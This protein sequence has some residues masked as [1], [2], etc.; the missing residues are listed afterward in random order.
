MEKKKVLQISILFLT[1]GFLLAVVQI[2]HFGGLTGFV[3][4]EQLNESSFGGGV[5]TKLLEEQ[6][7]E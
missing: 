5:S 2:W 3:V 7:E 4:F 6:E 1:L